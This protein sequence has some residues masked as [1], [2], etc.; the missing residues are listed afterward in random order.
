MSQ[1]ELKEKTRKAIEK[2]AEKGEMIL[3][4]DLC[5]ELS[6]K[7]KMP[8]KAVKDN[9]GQTLIC[10]SKETYDEKKIMLSVVVVDSKTEGMPWGGFFDRAKDWGAMNEETREKFFNDELR[11]VCREYGVEPINLENY[12]LQEL[13]KIARPILEDYAREGETLYYDDLAKEL[14]K[15]LPGLNIGRY[16]EILNSI[17]TFLSVEDYKEGKGMLSVVVIKNDKKRIPGRGFFKLA[18]ELDL[19]KLVGGSSEEAQKLRER[20]RKEF[21]DKE[22]DRVFAKHKG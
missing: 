6:Q 3:I 9:L 4:D 16:S 18:R 8:F 22:R 11:K 21:F 1:E 7:L 19:L 17:L 10:I 15:K 5:E 20:Q 13:K 12:D 14:N 2:V